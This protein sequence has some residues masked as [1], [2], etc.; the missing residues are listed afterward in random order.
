MERTRSAALQTNFPL[1]HADA[2][3]L[4]IVFAVL[5]GLGAHVKIPLPF[6]PVPLTLQTY[7]VL[8]TG[9]VLGSSYGLISQGFYLAVG[10]IGLPWFAFGGG[11]D[12][13]LGATGGYLLSYLLVTPLLGRK[14][15]NRP[16]LRVAFAWMLL[17]SSV[18]LVAGT[19]WLAA[20]TGVSISRAV[21]LGLL[22]FVA[23]DILKAAAA[24]A[25]LA[26]FRRQHAASR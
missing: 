13:L 9:A 21:W 23:G 25:T 1:S 6:T 8:L 4:A 7:F 19:L 18:I 2:M 11:P 22:P 10:V 16:S 24:A 12:Y 14:L 26:A 20:A 3:V 5:T 17:A 15:G